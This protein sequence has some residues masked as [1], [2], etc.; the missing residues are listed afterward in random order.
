MGETE[1]RARPRGFAQPR[2]PLGVIEQLLNAFQAGGWVMYPLLVMSLVAVTLIVERAAFWSRTHARGTLAFTNKVSA[3]LRGGRNDEARALSAK[4]GNIYARFTAELL[5]G[6]VS[7]SRAFELIE[8][9]RPKIERY[10]TALATIVAAAPLLGILGTVTG[11]IQSFNLIGSDDPVTD[12][13]AV[14]AGI[15][16]ALYTTAYGL[17]VALVALFPHAIYK[18]HSERCLARLE[19]MAAAANHTEKP[20]A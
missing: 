16:Q 14:A 12:P 13:T 1:Y 6:R 10:G 17:V 15:A 19:A 4:S 9:L 8:E 3:M 2:Y 11:I 5:A 20:E 7:E 18:T